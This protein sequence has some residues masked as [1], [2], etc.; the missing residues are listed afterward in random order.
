MTKRP[1]V[2]DF[3][4]DILVNF[5]TT[6]DVF[7]CHQLSGQLVFHESG[8]SK[9]PRPN[10]PHQLIP[11]RIMLNLRGHI[12]AASLSTSLTDSSGLPSYQTCILH[13]LSSRL[14]LL[15]LPLVSSEKAQNQLRKPDR[16]RRC[17]NSSSSSSSSSFAP[18]PSAPLS[19]SVI[20]PPALSWQL[21]HLQE[22]SGEMKTLQKV[23]TCNFQ[24]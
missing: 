14:L 18:F 12:H 10:I 6:L 1:M 20:F 7:Y 8:H 22:K 11:I 24:V 15:I 19:F 21:C 23:Q 17:P 3:P 2:D 16:I 4:L 13:H 9:I 5:L